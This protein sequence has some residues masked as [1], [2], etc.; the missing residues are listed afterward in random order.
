[1]GQ[2]DQTAAIHISSRSKASGPWPSRVSKMLG[3]SRSRNCA[4]V[5]QMAISTTILKPRGPS[6]MHAD[7][8]EGRARAPRGSYV[9]LA[10]CEVQYET[11]H[12]KTQFLGIVSTTRVQGEAKECFASAMSPAP[13]KYVTRVAS[14]SADFRAWQQVGHFGGHVG[15]VS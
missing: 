9:I 3:Q 13:M 8:R 1:M 7:G 11:S 5:I 6:V 15:P 12:W 14:L 2:L 4:S 10:S